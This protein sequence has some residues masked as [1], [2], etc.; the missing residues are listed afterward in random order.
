MARNLCSGEWIGEDGRLHY[1][2]E[3]FERLYDIGIGEDH[4]D[5]SSYQPYPKG[6]VC[7]KCGAVWAP[8]VRECEHC[9]PLTFI[10]VNIAG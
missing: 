1:A 10:Q 9:K 4:L 6:W 3:P 5:P 7:P 2:G 8:S